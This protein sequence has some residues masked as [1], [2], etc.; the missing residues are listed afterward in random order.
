MSD[1]KWKTAMHDCASCGRPAFP[2][3][4]KRTPDCPDDGPWWCD[5]QPNVTCECGA[6][7][8][9]VADGESSWVREVVR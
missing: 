5:S 6:E 7:L 4:Q 2:S 8:Q 3:L 1:P 9:L